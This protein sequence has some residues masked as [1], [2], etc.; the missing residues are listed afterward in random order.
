MR[1]AGRAGDADA[2]MTPEMRT[3]H[4]GQVGKSVDGAEP[5]S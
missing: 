1:C 2:G 5:A 3:E 4:N